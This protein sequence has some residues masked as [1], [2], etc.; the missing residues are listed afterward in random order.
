MHYHS[1]TRLLPRIF[2]KLSFKRS[3]GNIH[4]AFILLAI[5]FC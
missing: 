2:I 1:L 3:W 4:Q 5:D